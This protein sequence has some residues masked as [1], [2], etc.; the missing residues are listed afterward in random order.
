MAI[1]P[2]TKWIKNKFTNFKRLL[3][4]FA[5]AIVINFYLF[6]SYSVVSNLIII[7]S[8]FLVITSFLDFS[9][10]LKKFVK[11]N[12]SL[13]VWFLIFIGLNHNFSIE[14]DF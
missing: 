1:G 10:K 7:S 2:Q 4:I 14:K 13:I 12:F 5:G 3:V 6:T 9:K 11:N 8:L